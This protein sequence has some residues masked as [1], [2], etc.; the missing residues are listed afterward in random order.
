MEEESGDPEGQIDAKVKG[1]Q[2]NKGENRSEEE[3]RKQAEIEVERGK[4]VDK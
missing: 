1:I 2:G 3:I 4:K